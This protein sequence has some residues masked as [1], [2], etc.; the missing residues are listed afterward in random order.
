MSSPIV[1]PHTTPPNSAGHRHETAE[2]PP[3]NSLQIEQGTPEAFPEPTQR[4]C[5]AKPP[6][7]GDNM[8]KGEEWGSRWSKGPHKR[9]HVLL[10]QVDTGFSNQATGQGPR[11]LLSRDIQFPF[12]M[13]QSYRQPN[14]FSKPM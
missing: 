13:G 7:P 12:E 11:Q 8:R 1:T 3:A 9:P 5:P 4:C 6:M 2:L 10:W 14:F